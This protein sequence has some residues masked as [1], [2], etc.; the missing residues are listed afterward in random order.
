MAAAAA[1]PPAASTTI[2][3]SERLPPAEHL[4]RPPV[5][6][7]LLLAVTAFRLVV[8]GWLDP[9]PL[10]G[11]EAQY[12]IYGEHLAGGYY[13]KP[14]LLPW[15]MRLSTELLGPTAWAMRL[16][17]VLLHLAV[18]L[19][20]FG[21]GRRLY[22]P[23]VGLLAALV[24]LTL[25]AVS[26][27]SMIASTDPPM[28]LGWALATYA[29]IRALEGDGRALGWWALGGIGVGLGLLGKY[30]MIAWVVALAFVLLLDPHWRSRVSARG[31]AV[32]MAAAL[33]AFSPNLVWNALNGFPTLTHLG[34]NA[35]LAMGG[36]RPVGARATEALDFVL[37][38][39][40]VFGPIAFAILLWLLVR[41][42]TWRD[43]RL[44]LL[45]GLGLP[46]FLAITV[47]AWL[48][49]ANANWAAPVYLGFTVAVAVWLV[50]ERHRRLARGLVGLNLV[51]LLAVVGLAAANAR[52][53][54]S[55]SRLW[56]P[57]RLLRGVDR[58]VDEV[59]PFLDAEPDRWLL[60]TDRM[61]MAN[62]LERTGWPL[63]R[64]VIWNPD[65]SVTNHFEL[66]T[67]MPTDPSARFLL[68][69]HRGDPARI[70][71]H[72]DRHETALVAH[73]PTHAD[74]ALDLLVVRLEGFRSYDA[75]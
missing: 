52:E 27:S 18:A 7:A 21:I 42:A 37:S 61:L 25:P 75:Q 1:A 41:P 58:W 32:A 55:W 9:L 49:R 64:A 74:R 44:R 53:P 70:A 33:L 68:V 40:G 26:V 15:L 8:N 38:Q 24:Y 28:L 67:E 20:L 72:F 4:I 3:P 6:A 56:D 63:E 29:L 57:F 50:A 59:R 2:S 35:D 17:S 31:L 16:P 23:A 66:V 30:T 13:S 71:E 10:S 5:V 22:A 69:M 34:E 46:L 45:L 19:C 43:P 51:V 73:I 36:A 14:P 47:Q 12:W 54:T 62:V 39:A 65:G 60:M 48:N 11:D